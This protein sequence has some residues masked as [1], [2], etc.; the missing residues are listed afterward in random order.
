MAQRLHTLALACT[1]RRWAEQV[2]AGAELEEAQ[3]RPPSW[4]YPE[5]I[6]EARAQFPELAAIVLSA[7][8]LQAEQAFPK[9]GA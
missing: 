7:Y 1:V 8:S 9:P 6:D 2:L 5:G 3:K 4:P